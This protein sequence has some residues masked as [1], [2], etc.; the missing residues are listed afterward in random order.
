M[1]DRDHLG[2]PATYAPFRLQYSPDKRTW[3]N[4]SPLTSTDEQG[5]FTATDTAYHDG[6]WRVAVQGGTGRAYYPGCA[7]HA[8]VYRD[9]YVDVL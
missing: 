8:K 2:S 7:A 4:K 1:R 3:G 5:R 9:D 6:Y